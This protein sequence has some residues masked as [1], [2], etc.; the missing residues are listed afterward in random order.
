MLYILD[1][2][3]FYFLDFIK[4]VNM[5]FKIKNEFNFKYILEILI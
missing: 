1:F 2:Y 5:K 4:N 3:I